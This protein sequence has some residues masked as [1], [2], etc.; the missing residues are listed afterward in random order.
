MSKVD[1]FYDMFEKVNPLYCS[2]DDFIQFSRIDKIATPPDDE[3]EKVDVDKGF[4]FITE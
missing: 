2:I 1:K 3:E 4:N